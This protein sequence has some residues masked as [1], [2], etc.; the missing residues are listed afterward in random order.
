LKAV[1][2]L[3]P[4]TEGVVLVDGKVDDVAAIVHG[5]QACLLLAG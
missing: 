1:A 4:P 5:L 2:G 3:L